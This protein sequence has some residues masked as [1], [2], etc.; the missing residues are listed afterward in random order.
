LNIVIR[1]QSV[2]EQKTAA[3][4]SG[5]V[6]GRVTVLK[7]LAAASL[8]LAFTFG[9]AAIAVAQVT[10][11]PEPTGTSYVLPGA[12]AGY[13]GYR[14]LE[15]RSI[16]RMNPPGTS[17]DGTDERGYPSGEPQNPRTGD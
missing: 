15:G 2:P 12:V 8:F 11:P 1:E 3:G 14:L 17:Y 4:N 6:I 9:T 5:S 7:L 10:T 16:Y 13:P